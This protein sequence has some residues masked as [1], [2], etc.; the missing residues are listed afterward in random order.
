MIKIHT[1]ES[2]RYLKEGHA[3]IEAL[4][5]SNYFGE[6]VIF[7]YIINAL[8][9]YSE[10]LLINGPVDI[11]NTPVSSLEWISL[12]NEISKKINIYISNTNK[13]ILKP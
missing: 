11:A 13:G 7:T 4:M 1:P 8:H 6:Q 5:F 3:L 12:A 2:E 10:S 9:K